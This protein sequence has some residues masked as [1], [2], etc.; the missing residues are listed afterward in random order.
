M[1]MQTRM[2]EEIANSLGSLVL[3]ACPFPPLLS[4]KP[5]P[6]RLVPNEVDAGV[7]PVAVEIRETIIHPTNK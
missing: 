1:V 6:S 3:F 5:L 4:V 2:L 7:L